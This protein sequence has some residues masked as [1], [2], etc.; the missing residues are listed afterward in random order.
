MV[1]NYKTSNLV[2]PHSELDF[3]RLVGLEENLESFTRTSW[4]ERIPV[5]FKDGKTDYAIVDEE[6]KRLIYF[7]HGIS[8]NY[9][10]FNSS[11]QILHHWVCGI[12][13]GR[14]I[15][16]DLKVQNTQEMVKLIFSGTQSEILKFRGRL[17]I[18]DGEQPN[19]GWNV[20]HYPLKHGG[21]GLVDFI[22]GIV[23]NSHKYASYEPWVCYGVVSQSSHQRTDKRKIL[24]IATNFFDQRGFN[25]AKPFWAKDYERNYE[26]VVLFKGKSFYKD[27]PFTTLIGINFGFDNGLSGY[28][29]GLGFAMEDSQVAW[30]HPYNLQR[31][32]DWEKNGTRMK[33][34]SWKHHKNA[35]VMED[36]LSKFLSE[37]FE[38]VFDSYTDILNRIKEQRFPNEQISRKR[39]EAT[40]FTEF[41]D[42]QAQ[43]ADL[44]EQ[45]IARYGSTGYSHFKTWLGLASELDSQENGLAAS[46]ARWIAECV[47]TRI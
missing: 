22:G 37:S 17:N 16:R 10:R 30:L 36:T 32:P 1:L 42:Q 34:L 24:E 45:F 12:T 7:I 5:I 11:F 14:S 31:H 8:Q 26:P 3:T 25:I 4:D 23:D 28:R 15:N 19:L 39:L 43:L 20:L 6:R 41:K 38:N 9:H 29:V 47:L 27:A 44:H 46:R 33:H 21:E 40:H 35:G 18:T 2:Q 13:V